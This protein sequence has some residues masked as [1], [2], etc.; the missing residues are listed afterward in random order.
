MSRG[1]IST[2]EKLRRLKPLLTP[3]PI[4][5]KPFRLGLSQEQVE[6]LGAVMSALQRIRPAISAS[7]AM[8]C[9][10]ALA[11]RNIDGF[12]KGAIEEKENN[13]ATN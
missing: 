7:D 11:A 9:A 2:A 1:E 6:L 12:V 4:P 3:H 8:T 5:T 10:L 13:N